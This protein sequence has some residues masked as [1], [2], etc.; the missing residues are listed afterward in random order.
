ME[1]QGEETARELVDIRDRF[2]Q[3]EMTGDAEFFE[4]LLADDAVIMAPGPPA[5]EGKAACMEFIR[6]VLL[7]V[8]REFERYISLTS[9]EVRL[10][11][12]WAF[13]RG[14]FSQRLVRRDDRSELREDGKYFWLY[15]RTAGSW[16]L[17]RIVGNYDWRDEEEHKG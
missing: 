5:L 8:N 1:K 9:A 4:F 10:N 7:D 15:V 13:D 2:A 16:K 6:G 11:G 17:A 3:A 14:T 12:D